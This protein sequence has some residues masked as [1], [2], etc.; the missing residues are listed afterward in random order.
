M[1]AL[2]IDA[3][4]VTDNSIGDIVLADLRPIVTR[5]SALAGYRVDMLQRGYTPTSMVRVDDYLTDNLNN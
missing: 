5:V 1:S 2:T 3:T 4:R